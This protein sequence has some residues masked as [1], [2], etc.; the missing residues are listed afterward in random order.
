MENT[1]SDSQIFGD[2]DQSTT[3]VPGNAIPKVTVKFDGANWQN[4]GTE[5]K[6]PANAPIKHNPGT[7]I[8]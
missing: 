3:S 7:I 8:K 6:H 5:E 2:K 1:D 4:Q